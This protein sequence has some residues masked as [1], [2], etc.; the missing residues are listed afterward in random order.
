MASD[1]A[2]TIW[3]GVQFGGGVQPNGYAGA[4]CV[5]S[6]AWRMTSMTTP[7]NCNPSRPS[8]SR[9][10]LSAT[11]PGNPRETATPA[12]A[13]AHEFARWNTGA[14]SGLWSR[15]RPFQPASIPAPVSFNPEQTAGCG[16]CCGLQTRAPAPFSPGNVE[17]A[18]QQQQFRMGRRILGRISRMRERLGA[19]FSRKGAQVLRFVPAELLQVQDEAAFA[20]G[21]GIGMRC[22]RPCGVRRRRGLLPGASRPAVWRAAVP[23]G[24]RVRGFATLRGFPP[25][26]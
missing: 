3:S 8:S 5:A 25:R 13:A 17:H 2:V 20:S 22:A 11:T 6:S 24:R 19:S 4:R 21:Q 23:P 16:R 10:R 18:G 15:G 26:D 9:T 12:R 1:R 7:N 14:R